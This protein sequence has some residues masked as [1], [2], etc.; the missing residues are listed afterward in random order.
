MPSWSARYTSPSPRPPRTWRRSTSSSTSRRLAVGDAAKLRRAIEAGLRTGGQGWV[1]SNHD[2]SRLVTRAGPDNA[3][4]VA[5]LLLSLPGPAFLFQGDELGLA[6]TPMA[7]PEQDRNHRDPFRAPMVWDI[8]AEYGA[9]SSAEPW[10]H[11]S[12]PLPP[13]VAQQS[14]DP[15]STL[16]LIRATIALRSDLRA[17]PA[18]L[19]PAAAGSVALRRGGHVIA[20]N[21]ADEPVDAPAAGELTLEARPGDG[22][23]LSV[24]PAHG[25]WIAT[26]PQSRPAP[27]IADKLLLTEVCVFPVSG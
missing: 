7:G 18:Q 2:F 25:G 3:R 13:G 12:G 1:L 23:D 8:N 22:A 4:A 6:D 10:L 20:V 5:L 17:K 16:A 9:F 24:V 27:S 19:L 15:G 14:A 11:P 26:L 21:L